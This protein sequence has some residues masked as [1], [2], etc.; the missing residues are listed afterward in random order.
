[1]LSWQIKGL[2]LLASALVAIMLAASTAGAASTPSARAAAQPVCASVAIAW[3]P[4]GEI[5]V[6]TPPASWH[7]A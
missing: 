3:Q 4:G 2:L 5:V 6:T 1:M 7:D